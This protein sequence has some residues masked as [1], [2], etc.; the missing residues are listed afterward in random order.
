MQLGSRPQAL[1]E[2][3]ALPAPANLLPRPEVRG[4]FIFAGDEKLYLRGV[5]YGTFRPDSAGGDYPPPAVVECDFARMAANGIN[6]LRTYTPPPIWLLDAARRHG[7]YV[8]LGLPWEEHV[9]FLD[10]HQ[11]AHDIVERVRGQVRTCA[12]HPAVLGYA[13]GNEIPAPIVRWHGARRIARFLERLYQ[14]VKAEDPHALVTYVNYPS[15]EYLELPFVDFVCFNVYLESPDAFSAYLARL[16]NLA[17]NRPLVLAELGLDSRRNGEETQACTLSWQLRAA[18]AAGVAGAFVFAWTD[19]WYRGGYEVEDWDFGLT[20]RQRRPKPA[21]DAVRQVFDAAPFPPAR[22][23]PRISV[24]VCS[25]NGMGTIDDCCA[26]LSRLAYPDYEVIVVD[27]GSR[28]SLAAVVGKY[29]FRTITTPNRGLS[30][31]RNTGLAAATGEIVAYLDDDAHPDPHWLTYLAATFL[32]TTYAGVG[33]PNIPPPG[34]GPIAECVANAPGGPTHVLVSDHEAEHLPGCNMAF[35]VEP[36]RAIG[37]FDPRFRAAG[38]DVDVCWRLQARGWRL[39]FSPGAVV[40]HHRRNSVRT[41]WKQQLGYGQAEALLERK[42]PEKYNG[43]GHLTWAG[44]LYGLGLPRSLNWLR[45]RIY[46]GPGGSAPFQALYQPAPG[47][48]WSL[49]LMPEW[50]LAIAVLAGL[51]ALGVTWSPLLLAGP[52]L[53]L[54]VG[55]LLVQ[56]ALGAARASFPSAPR[57]RLTR[58]RLRLLTSALYLLQPLARLLGRW[59]AGLVPWRRRGVRGVTWPLPGAASLWSERWRSTTDWLA[60]LDT[61]LRA[62]GA[63]V[64]GGGDYDHWDLEARDGVLGTARALLVVEEHGGGRQL[65][66]VRWWP[67]YSPSVLLLGLPLVALATGAAASGAPSVGI[68]FAALAVVL[69]LRALHECAVA[70]GALRR[71][72]RQVG[73]W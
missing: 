27:D 49:S 2:R 46:Q 3:I 41:Y 67:R 17:L 66:R 72:L 61:A 73:A 28:D 53:A 45:G 56:A 62:T 70:I 43:A 19:E 37:G 7:L 34:D 29:G 33:G 20:D 23:W 65:V 13:I 21:L 57:G 52:L 12:G 4:K 39:G 48:V 18:F 40:W 59:R 51:T 44:R 38:D 58:W 1:L 24:V 32:S 26:G 69:V 35:R 60:T 16:Q 11:R 25:Y 31:A 64:R 22:R 42:W 68:L 14:V 5:T 63:S 30:S 8:L 47:V 6:T 55:A 36:L 50:Y 71:A 9:T 54:A 15:T 10:D